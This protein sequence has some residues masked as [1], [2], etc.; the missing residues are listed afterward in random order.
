MYTSFEEVIDKQL[1][2]GRELKTLEYD[3]IRDRLSSLARSPYGREVCAN[4]YPSGDIDTVSNRQAETGD[5]IQFIT[6]IGQIPLSGLY[7]VRSLIAY[8]ENDGILSMKDLLGVACFLRAVDRIRAVLPKENVSEKKNILVENIRLLTT[9]PD[10]EKEISFCIVSE[11]EMN[12]RAS[13]ELYSLRKKIR[14]AQSGIRETLEKIIRNHSS[15]LQEQLVTLR[16][17]R[18]VVPVKAE[19]RG[20]IP[21]IVHDTSSSGQTVFVEPMAVVEENNRIRQWL[22]N[23]QEEISRILMLLSA[24]VGESSVLLRANVALLAQID[25]FCAKAA[26]ATEMC[27]T[28]PILNADG[29]ICL[30]KARHPLIAEDLVVPIDFTV[31]TDF[32]TLVVTGPNTGGKTV[33]LKTCGLLTLMTMAGLFIPCLDHSEVSVFRKVLAD[34]GDEQSIE[35][36]LSTFS[37]HMKNL[38]HILSEAEASTLVLVDELGSG[39]DP[40]EGA[41]LAI[42]ILDECRKM[43]AVTVATTHY[44]E[45]KG[46]AIQTPGVQNAC[47][48]FDTETLSPT[49]RLL[50]G[51][52]GVS[53]AFVISEKLGLPKRIIDSAQTFLTQDGIRF[54]ELLSSA[55]KNNRES[56]KLKKEIR[57]M[58]DMVK[59]Q[60]RELEKERIEIDNSRMKILKD[61]NEQKRELLEEALEE[62]DRALS[63][64]QSRRKKKTLDDAAEKAREIRTNLRAGL[65]NLE[66]EMTDTDPEP[67][68]GKIPDEIREGGQY[69]SPALGVTGTLLKGPDSKG[70]CILVSGSLKLTVPANTLR[71]P[72]ESFS[73]SGVLDNGKK[74]AGHT[75]NLKQFSSSD[76]IRMKRIAETSPELMLIGKSVDE[77]IMELDRYLD[78]CVLSN[79]SFVRIVHG[80]GSGA[81]RSAVSAQLKNDSRIR[82]FRLGTV[83]EGGDGVT[84]AEF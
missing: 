34:I 71:Y 70:N 38:V 72:E 55:E 19:K 31:G 24:K 62:C 40:S 81:L 41:A 5:T 29:K 32:R 2:K 57:D 53:N 12:D 14:T 26:L 42:A 54:E 67:V 20:D 51:L 79:I 4:L 16:D 21:G 37:S 60:S 27:A 3:K 8:A 74:R 82:K 23:E 48:E 22:A 39:T 61:A 10:L 45:L 76:K 50:I 47:C 9:A 66:T 35:Q 83:G 58:R 63:D 36:S 59:R 52:P 28:M 73:K 44:K 56:E 30:R 78:D 75:G 84:I 68:P 18:Y 25:F 7:D 13:D 65:S 77:A 80:K 6:S 33:S 69:S 15:A 11:E 49:Y 43:G 17:N 64:I 46:Y 1:L